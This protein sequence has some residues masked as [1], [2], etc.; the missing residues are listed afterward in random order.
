[1]AKRFTDTDIW[2]KQRWFKKLD[3]IYKLVFCYIKDQCNHAGVW[4]IDCTD[5]M[6]DLGIEEFDLKHFIQSVNID[7]D[8]LTGKKIM[9]ERVKVVKAGKMLWLTGFIQ[10][11][12][13]GKGGTVNPDGNVAY[14][15]L[16]ML[17]QLKKYL[18]F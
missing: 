16:F 8:R 7:Y 3:P 13:E 4:K 14:S 5:L 2:K 1:M 9:K 11:Q 10:F 12:C 18:F 17:S 6:E 15:S